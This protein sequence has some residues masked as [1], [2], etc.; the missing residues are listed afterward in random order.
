M[1]V[2]ADGAQPLVSFAVRLAVAET[3]REAGKK[4]Y[5]MSRFL[6]QMHSGL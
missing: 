1:E 6:L 5:G 3:A 2:I 4:G